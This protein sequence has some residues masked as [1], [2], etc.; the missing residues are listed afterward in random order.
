MNKVAEAVPRA[1]AAAVRIVGGASFGCAPGDTVLRAG[2]RAGLG[3]PYECNAGGCGSCKFDLLS[4]DMDDLWPQAPG[5]RA[6]DRERGRHLAC[7]SIPRSDCEIKLRT[8]DRY[9]PQSLPQRLDARYLGSRAVTADIREFDFLAPGAAN[10]LPGQYALLRLPAAGQERAYSMSNQPNVQGLW[11]F[12]VRHVPGGKVSAGLFALEEGAEVGIDAPYGIAHLR[13]SAQRDI[14]C[15]AGGSG[16]APMVS[17]INGALAQPALGEREAWLFYGGRGPAD[18]PM[19]DG[20]IHPHPRVRFHPAI[21][22]PALAE[23]TDWAGEV[24]MVH[25]ML[26]R[27]LPHAL[28]SYEYYLAG[29]PPMIEAVVRML[30]ADHRVAAEAIHYDRFF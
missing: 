3:L 2:L 13:A 21:S 4:G 27:K 25:E 17:I 8:A 12:M 5:I 10:F 22:V 24:G 6:K 28:A 30:Q 26:P 15:I 9:V 23:G 20:F 19:I 1:Q 14:V 7:Q 18:I 11:R 16:L 29:P